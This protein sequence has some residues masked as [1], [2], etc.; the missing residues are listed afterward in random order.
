ENI[1]DILNERYN[2][3]P[4]ECETGKPAYYCS[5]IMLR[6]GGNLAEGGESGYPSWSLGP[7]FQELGSGSFSYIRADLTDGARSIFLG[8]ANGLILTDATTAEDLGKAY[9]V[10][11]AFPLDAHIET[12]N[13]TLKRT[14][15]GCGELVNIPTN[16]EEDDQ[17]LS[18]CNSKAIFDAKD[19]I[20]QQI[21]EYGSLTPFDPRLNICSFSGRL[22]SFIEIISALNVHHELVKS[23]FMEEQYRNNINEVLI[24]AVPE[25]SSDFGW[26]TDHPERNSIQAFWYGDDRYTSVEQSRA[27]ALRDRELFYEKTGLYLPVVKLENKL[28]PRVSPFTYH[29]EDN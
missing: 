29:E 28:N 26:S 15:H 19:W 23:T 22:P 17:D 14:N 21:L 12:R 27:Y 13:V 10:R 9:E 2:S 6:V 4:T 18:T 1:A 7:S 16:N 20:E 5:G 24:K 25:G 8:S 11:C 3:T